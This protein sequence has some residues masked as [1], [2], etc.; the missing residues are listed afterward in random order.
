MT[1]AYRIQRPDTAFS[2]STGKKRPREHNDGHLKFIRSLPCLI[3]RSRANIEAAHI[4][5]GDPRYGKSGTGMAE[6]P[7][8]KWTVPLCHND[9]QGPGGQ[10]S[11]GEKAWW[12]KQ[13]I[14]PLNIA[15]ALFMA[16]GDEEA[17]EL[18]ISKAIADR[19]SRTK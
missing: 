4:R 9:H 10:H 1:T 13:G 11:E 2:M 18:I 15:A 16:S 17:G 7:S 19:K 3:C 12:D 6:K 8:D 14:D 5:F